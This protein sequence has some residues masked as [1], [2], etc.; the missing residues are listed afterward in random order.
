MSIYPE[1]LS[2]AE[3]IKENVRLAAE[4]TAELYGVPTAEVSITLTNNAYRYGLNRE[5]R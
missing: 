4:K 1:E 3:E 5:L 2:F